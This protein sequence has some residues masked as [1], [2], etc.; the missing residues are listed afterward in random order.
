MGLKLLLCVAVFVAVP[1]YV[2]YTPIPD[3]YSTMSACKMQLKLAA[4]NAAV[5][6][7]STCSEIICKALECSGRV[8]VSPSV[9]YYFNSFDRVYL[10]KWDSLFIGLYIY[11]SVY[12]FIHK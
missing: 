4:I 12:P 10:V 1:A 2:L 5:S 3:G 11:T 7:V 8:A 6:L 9:N